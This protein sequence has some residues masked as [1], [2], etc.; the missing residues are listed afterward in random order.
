MRFL[1]MA[2]L[3][4]SV[5]EQEYS[6]SVFQ[7]ALELAKREQCQWVLIC[8]DL[9]DS[10]EDLTRL[11]EEV[12]NRI[13]PY[14]AR[15]QIFFIP[16]NHE[17]RKVPQAVELLKKLDLGAVQ[18]WADSDYLF[19][20]VAPGVEVLAVPFSTGPLSVEN[21]QIPSK[22]GTFRI[23]AAHGMV[24]GA[25]YQGEG[26]EEIGALDLATFQRFEIDYAALGHLHMPMED[27]RGTVPFVYPGSARV[28][29][30]GE[31][32]PR[33]VVIWELEGEK[34][35]SGGS[36][37]SSPVRLHRHILRSAG[38]FLSIEVE[39]TWEGNLLEPKVPTDVGKAD[40]IQLTPVGI[41]EDERKTREQVERLRIELEKRVRKV[42]VDG[43]KLEWMEGISTHP[44]AQ[45]FLSL[46][47]SQYQKA[48][49][50]EK[51]ILR[52]ARLHGLRTIQGLRGGRR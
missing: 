36:S 6:L 38:R 45:R 50:E 29:R 17:V 49:A 25:V 33:S 41:T 51:E 26:E 47:E 19:K 21:W 4:L 40:W 1:H 37:Q 32:G 23:L 10:W 34:A 31:E 35:S 18:V 39:V 44:L 14:A 3:H 13:E 7:E 20:Q 42:T 22:Q 2:D 24:P 43:T 15:F 27:Q 8:G 16:G 5:K 9:F 48:T 52:Y 30:A 46:W 11:R 12:R 28:W